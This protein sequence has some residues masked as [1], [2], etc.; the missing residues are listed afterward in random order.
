MEFSKGEKCVQIAARISDVAETVLGK[1][2]VGE[3][4]FLL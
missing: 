1:T 2:C 3:R 4:V